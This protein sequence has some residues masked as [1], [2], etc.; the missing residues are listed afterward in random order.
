MS[1]VI[2]VFTVS[3]IR[4]LTDKWQR[5]EISYSRMV[6]E[7]NEMVSQRIPTPIKCSKTGQHLFIGDMVKGSQG[8]HGYL[9]FED[10][11]NQFVIRSETGGNFKTTTFEK[12][13]SLKPNVSNTGVEC[14]RYPNKKKW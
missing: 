3:D 2:K 7:M 12:V 14:R 11:L 4:N 5:A 8:Q 6:H 1:E 10:Y 13:Q 9:F